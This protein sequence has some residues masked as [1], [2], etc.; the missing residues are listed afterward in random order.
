VTAH[1]FFVPPDSVS[2]EQI[3]IS[4]EEAHHALRV[5]RVRKGEAITVADGTGRVYEAVVE[6]VS[7][8]VVAAVRRSYA[9]SQPP[10]RI[11]VFQALTKSDRFE[12]VVEKATELGV[13]SIVPF[14][15]ARS[16]VRWDERKKTKAVQRWRSI[17]LAAAK[18]S[19]APKVPKVG[20]VESGVG[21][22][23]GCDPVLVLHEGA[24]RKLRE[25]LPSDPPDRL[26][27]VIGPE[28]G[29]EDAE[30][31]LFS[32]D[33]VV[34]LGPQ[35]FRTETAGLVAASAISYAYGNLG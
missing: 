32:D 25:A 24:A 8:V 33:S 30:L 27:L 13:S 29:L 18:Q 5:L 31:E 23:A 9:V 12:L 16:V 6:G 10:P 28:G 4:G 1:H 3:E 34:S 35:V 19:K 15:A 11:T 17:A 14:E 20:E 21:A 22:A 2:E 7:D 26:S